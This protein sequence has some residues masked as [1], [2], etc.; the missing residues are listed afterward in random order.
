MSRPCPACKTGAE[1]RG[2]PFNGGG[3]LHESRDYPLLLHCN[4][5][6]RYFRP[7][8]GG[9]VLVTITTRCLS[10]YHGVTSRPEART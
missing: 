10:Q 9:M 6:G 4:Y 7:D 1:R 2:L 5:C 8:E 3:H